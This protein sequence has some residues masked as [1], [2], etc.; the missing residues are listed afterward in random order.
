MW[1]SVPKPVAENPVYHDLALMILFSG[2]LD[3][4]E[5]NDLCIRVV[6]VATN[7]EANVAEVFRIPQCLEV[8][9]KSALVVGI[10][11]VCVNERLQTLGG[12]AAVAFDDDPVDDAARLS[13]AVRH[14]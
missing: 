12:H 13:N 8:P 11:Y 9:L 1:E 2:L 14:Y 6:R 3:E 4:D 5:V 10:A 7:F